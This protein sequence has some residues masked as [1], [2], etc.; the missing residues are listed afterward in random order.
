MVRYVVL[1]FFLLIIPLHSNSETS[2]HPN[3]VFIPEGEFIMGSNDAQ[4]PFPLGTIEDQKREG[5]KN[6]EPMHKV[7]LDPFWIDKYEVTNQEFKAFLER[8]GYQPIEF[9]MYPLKNKH[10]GKKGW[11]WSET[12]IFW[13]P[14][15]S[16][17]HTGQIPASVERD[18]SCD[19]EF[20][21]FGF[22]QKK[23]DPAVC[24]SW[25]DATAY[26]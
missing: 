16:Y 10:Y 9:C 24:V 23:T 21:P 25:K 20:I 6:E 13:I 8:T 15:Y 1:L 3:M 17:W 26:C 5:F 2:K 19:N 22:D 4:F 7:Y 14:E 18:S 12:H 11:P